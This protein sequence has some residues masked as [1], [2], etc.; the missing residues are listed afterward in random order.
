MQIDLL[1]FDGCPGWREAQENLNAAL[2]AEGLEAETHPV[3]VENNAE[4]ARLRFL[5]SPSFR[6]DGVDLWPEQRNRY[7]LSCR[8]Y[9]TPQGLKGAPTAEMLREKLRAQSTKKV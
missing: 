9:P 3:L 4:A 7:N 1:Y 6:V 2:Q 5:G 8:V